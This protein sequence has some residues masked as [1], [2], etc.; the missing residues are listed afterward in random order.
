M[1]IH[2]LFMLMVIV[3]I[4][5]NVNYP[6]II[7]CFLNFLSNDNKFSTLYLKPIPELLIHI[8]ENSKIVVTTIGNGSVNFV[9]FSCF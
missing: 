6:S 4:Y 3:S 1:F 5:V 2:V 9:S 7:I 8:T